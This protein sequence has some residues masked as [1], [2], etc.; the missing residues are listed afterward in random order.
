MIVHLENA[1]ISFADG[2][3]KAKAIEDGQ[4]PKFGSDFILMPETVV[5]RC[6]EKGKRVFKT[7]MKDVLLAVANET[8][9]NR[10]QAMLDTLEASKKCYRDGNLRMKKDGSPYDGYE[11]YWYVTAKNKARPT[12]RD[13]NPQVILTEEDGKPY[14]GSYVTASIDVYGMADPKR[15]GVFATLRGV[16]FVKDGDAFS[17][18]GRV[19]GDD[20]FADLGEGAT[21]DD[22][23]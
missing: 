1:R 20:E 17:G 10:G 12:V 2:L 16:Q 23:L 4:T 6:D 18:G 9:K 19:A 8:W 3:W 15:K 22:L 7:T 14:S 21:A 11:G 13:R 5:W